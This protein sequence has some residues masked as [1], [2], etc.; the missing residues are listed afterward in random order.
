VPL[1]AALALPPLHPPPP[2]SGRAGKPPLHP[3]TQR[4]DAF[5][6]LSRRP[7]PALTSASG[8]GAASDDTLGLV[9]SPTLLSAAA[10]PTSGAVA[11]DMRVDVS[12]GP[13]SP[14][15]FVSPARLPTASPTASLSPAALS[16]TLVSQFST[17]VAEVADA[18]VTALQAVTPEL[19]FNPHECQDRLASFQEE[20]NA[21]TVSVRASASRGDTPQQVAA[22]ALA[23]RVAVFRSAADAVMREVELM[24]PES[25]AALELLMQGEFDTVV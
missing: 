23:G 16:A 13:A 22:A 10:G 11:R 17:C 19:L 20:I 2:T 4:V 18:V 21:S 7:G 6:L 3:S 8:S 15:G 14:S 24:H 9:L 1:A 12:G 5:T 25:A